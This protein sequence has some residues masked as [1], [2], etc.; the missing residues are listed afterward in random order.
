MWVDFCLVAINEN[1]QTEAAI[2]KKWVNYWL[3]GEFLMSRITN[4]GLF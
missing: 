3:H 4:I 1:A 2:G